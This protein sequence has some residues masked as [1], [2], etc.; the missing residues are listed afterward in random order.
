[1]CTLTLPHRRW[2][3]IVVEDLDGSD[4]GEVELRALCFG[5]RGRQCG[6]GTDDERDNDVRVGEEATMRIEEGSRQAAM[7]AEGE[8]CGRK[9]GRREDRGR[10]VD[11]SC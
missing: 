3:S 5:R 4:N 9:G 11:L 8:D 7:A 1:M 6:S 10:H 2:S